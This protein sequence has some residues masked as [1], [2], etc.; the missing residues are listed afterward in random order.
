MFGVNAAPGGRYSTPRVY[1]L[2]LCDQ[3]L[4]V[5]G[6]RKDGIARHIAFPGWAAVPLV[7]KGATWAART[8]EN[9]PFSRCSGRACRIG[10]ITTVTA[11]IS[12]AS[13]RATS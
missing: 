3:R 12:G 6:D 11:R 13:V 2:T 8:P 7:R 9:V 10:A 5:C 4:G 1:S